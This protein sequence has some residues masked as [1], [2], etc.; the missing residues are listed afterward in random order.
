MFVL[1]IGCTVLG[2]IGVC[3]IYRM[4]GVGEYQYVCP[5]YRMHGVGEYRYVCPIYRMQ[6]A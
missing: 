6:G 2:S 1:Y 5:I 4:H 3:P